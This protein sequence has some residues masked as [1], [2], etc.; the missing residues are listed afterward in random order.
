MISV[1]FNVSFTGK[2]YSLIL[3]T[4][5][6]PVQSY[7]GE[8][9]Q[10]EMVVSSSI[11]SDEYARYVSV[12]LFGA[13]IRQEQ[14]F[15]DDFNSVINAFNTMHLPATKSTF[16]QAILRVCTKHVN[17][18]GRIWIADALMYVDCAMFALKAINEWSDSQCRNCYSELASNVENAMG[19]DIK[20][21]S[22]YMSPFNF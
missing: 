13:E 17:Q 14:E 9:S 5:W 21:P 3:P 4:T 15:K 11:R 7:I 18:Y 8:Q 2:S 19:N 16:K 12:P 6:V 1:S 22:S 10:A 20:Y